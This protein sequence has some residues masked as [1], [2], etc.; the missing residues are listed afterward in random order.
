MTSLL[1]TPI[2]RP[3][4]VS[5]AVPLAN[6]TASESVFADALLRSAH[7][8][9]ADIAGL[10]KSF[11]ITAVSELGDKTFLISAILATRHSLMLVFWGSWLAMICM[12]TLSSLMGAILPALLSHQHA[13]FLSGMLFLGFG[14][15]MLWQGMHMSGDEIS[16]EWK[17]AQEEI[18][19]DE[20]EHELD[21]LEAGMPDE[22]RSTLQRASTALHSAP[23]TSMIT[24]LRQGIRN[25]FDLC[26]SP[27]F[28]QAFLLSFLGEWGDK[29]Q[30]TTMALATTHRVTVVAIGTSLAHLLCIVIAVT[31]AAS[32]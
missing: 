15:L 5:V 27:V 10:V 13:L 26:V 29:S 21:A 28:S 19:V 24:F 17:E 22:A 30:I 11:S 7:L 6:G 2:V 4:I 23:R 1:A 16:E 14:G 20:E 25:L 9:R 18:R 32:T 31:I 3:P 12:S 8:T